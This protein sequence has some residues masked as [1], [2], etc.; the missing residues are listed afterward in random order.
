MKSV[1]LLIG[2][3]QRAHGVRG[4]IL[5]RSLTDDDARFTEGMKCFLVKDRDAEPYGE[6]TISNIRITPSGLL[7]AL[8][9]CEDRETARSYCGSYLAVNREDAIELRDDD[10]FYTG[11]LVGARVI[12]RALGDLGELV[13]FISAGG[14]EVLVVR[15]PGESDVLIPF[16][17]SIVPYVDIEANT[18]EVVLPEGLFELYRGSS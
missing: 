10:E 13:D 7:L 4:E 14:S 17:K 12:D 3:L 16:L 8:R 5:T 2:Y 1:R 6:V 9:G 15:K 11:D 18:I